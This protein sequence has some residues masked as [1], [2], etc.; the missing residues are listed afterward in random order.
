MHWRWRRQFQAST[1]QL[2][3]GGLQLTNTCQSRLVMLDADDKVV[4]CA[5]EWRS[6]VHVPHDKCRAQQLQRPQ[7]PLR[8]ATVNESLN[9]LGPS[10]FK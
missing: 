9:G 7:I 4:L 5:P 3:V 1:G 10:A 2:P 8:R 6:L